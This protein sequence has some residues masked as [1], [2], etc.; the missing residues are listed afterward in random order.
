MDL[1]FPNVLITGTPGVG[2]TTLARLL[3]DQL[4]EEFPGKFNLIQVSKLVLDQKLYRKW[5]DEFNVPEFDEDLL[6]DALE[7]LMNSGGQIVDFH[8]CSFFPQAWFQQVILLRASNTQIFDRLTERNYPERKIRE[9][10]EAEIFNVVYDEVFESFPRNSI[11][12]LDSNTVEEMQGNLEAS[13][14][15][16]KSKINN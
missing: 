6:C 13:L 16:I 8:S 10:V 12:C 1:I 15:Q 9:N 4:S 14:K 5:N 3:E 11:I 7:P 2:K